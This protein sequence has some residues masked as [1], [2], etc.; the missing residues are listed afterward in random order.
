MWQL[1]SSN[2]WYSGQTEEKQ[3]NDHPEWLEVFLR[4]QGPQALGEQPENG[5]VRQQWRMKYFG[6]QHC[7]ETSGDFKI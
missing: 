6:T 5:E 2:G 3:G 4:Q 7:L 1:F